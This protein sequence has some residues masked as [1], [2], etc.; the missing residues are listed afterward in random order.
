[1]L[2]I[3]KHA[4][5]PSSVEVITVNP[6]NPDTNLAKALGTDTTRS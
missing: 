3:F 5:L 2:I 4:V 1:M 6:T